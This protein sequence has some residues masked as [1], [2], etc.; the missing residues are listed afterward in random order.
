MTK[1]EIFALP[2]QTTGRLIV[3]SDTGDAYYIPSG[4]DGSKALLTG[5]DGVESRLENPICLARISNE[6][7]AFSAPT[8]GETYVG[9]TVFG[10]SMCSSFSAFNFA[11]RE[12]AERYGY[13]ALMSPNLG[14]SW[15]GAA[16]AFTGGATQLSSDWGRFPG[17]NEI[18]IP[19][20]GTAEI[21]L[22]PFTRVKDPSTTLDEAKLPDTNNAFNLP[23][24]IRQVSVFYMAEPGAGTLDVTISQPGGA[25]DITDSLNCDAAEQL[26]RA[27]YTPVNRAG[28]TTVNLAVSTAAV[29]VV[30][31][32]W[33]GDSGVYIL[34]SNVG[35]ST[36][37]QQSACLSSGSFKQPYID[38][39][40]ELNV[41]LVLHAQRAGGDVNWETNYATFFD[42]YEALGKS[43][44]VIGEP[45]LAT[46]G[47]P[48]TDEFNEFLRRECSL[49]GIGYFDTKK[50]ASYAL[51]QE[52]AWEG[53]GVHLGKGYHRHVAG[54]LLAACNYF[55]SALSS[56]GG[57]LSR[58]ALAYER[59]TL[60][61][62]SE[63]RTSRIIARAG[64]T[65]ET[66][67]ASGG[68][69]VSTSNE[70][71]F[72]FVGVAALGGCAARIGN[73]LSGSTGIETNLWPVAV[74]GNGYRNVS[75]KN[76][77]R[78]FILFGGS[79]VNVTTLTGLTQKC[80]GLEFAN[81]ADVGSPDGL[82]NEVV[83]VF[84]CD[85]VTVATSPWSPLTQGGEG[86]PE[87][88]GWG[89]M[90]RWDPIQSTFYMYDGLNN[91]KG[92]IPKMRLTLTFPA[93]KTAARTSGVWVHCGLYAEDGG[94]VPAAAAEMSWLNITSTWGTFMTPYQ[95]P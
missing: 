12:M 17:A 88:T 82:E 76:G 35:G 40:N 58:N 87:N 44:I 49:R 65:T 57:V 28:D 53:D 32:V 78:A 1:T 59:F 26:M 62:L 91:S 43:Q 4:A 37:T 13:G 86:A 7:Q 64:L 77:V 69:T 92:H 24:G 74:T 9:I 2:V 41:S 75:M 5:S 31:V 50:L 51:L 16:W 85:G 71:G 11:V 45:P 68:Y 27:D 14:W 18:N 39:L 89:F 90:L 23:G 48:T 81:G 54:H 80:F 79:A 61:A 46:E 6:I 72:R 95:T 29:R 66:P 42:A 15:N 70:R 56:P 36:M 25:A 21:T 30:G 33:W 73:V 52:V 47:D 3:A 67:S 19:P 94:N 83:R 93:L 60:G 38:L 22:A 20:G 34:T 55:A 10:D 84:A 63:T 8:P